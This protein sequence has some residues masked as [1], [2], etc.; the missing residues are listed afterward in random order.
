[1]SSEELRAEVARLNV[2]LAELKQPTLWLEEAIGARLYT[3]PMYVKY[4]AVLRGWESAVRP[5]EAA[6]E[7]LCMGN[8]YVTT[9]NVINSCVVKLSVLTK[10]EC[11]Y[12]G[13]A[14]GLLPEAFRIADR[15]NVRGGV[16]AGFMSTSLDRDVAISYAGSGSVGALFEIK[17]GMVDRGASLRTLSQYPHEVEVLFGPLA[18]LEV[19]SSRVEG[20]VVVLSVRLNINLSAEPLEKVVARA[21][22][23]IE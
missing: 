11:V 2:Q 17:Q 21:Q 12:R 18:C 5:L 9:L 13:L 7:Q 3:G 20:H 15:F 8:A 14:G 23:A 1:M 10:A 16:E 4:N 6:F 22:R 19:Q